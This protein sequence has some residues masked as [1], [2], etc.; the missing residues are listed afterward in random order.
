[1]LTEKDAA[2]VAAA[3]DG[4]IMEGREISVR[5]A[6]EKT[7]PARPART[8]RPYVTVRATPNTISRPSDEPVRAK[9]PRRTQ[10]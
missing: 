10:R 5:Q 9:R 7:E 3:L 4:T 2:Q 8:H 1:M 6:V